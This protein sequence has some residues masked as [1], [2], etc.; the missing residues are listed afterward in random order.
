[1]GST[2]KIR[3]VGIVARKATYPVIAGHP[4]KEND[5]VT[6][7]VEEDA[8]VTIKW[9]AG[10][11][12]RKSHKMRENGAECAGCGIPPILLTIIRDRQISCG[13][14]CY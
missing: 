8:A 2:S 1:L 3:I 12:G 9:M 5:M 14:E 10:P 13:R 7:E 4:V 6:D 11:T